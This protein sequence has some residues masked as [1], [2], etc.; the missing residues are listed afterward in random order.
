MPYRHAQWWIL[1]LFPLAGL[2]FW[3]GYLSVIPTSPPSYHL[4]GVTASLWLTLLIV[5]SWS[6]HHGH[7]TFHRTNGLVSLTLF[8][9]FLAGGAAIF[10]SA[11][12]AGAATT[13]TRFSGSATLAAATAEPRKP[14]FQ[15]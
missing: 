14:S 10:G 11:T 5:Q 7:R 9:L 3:P 8:P 2:A 12:T 4:H 13:L 1:G 15:S 6:I